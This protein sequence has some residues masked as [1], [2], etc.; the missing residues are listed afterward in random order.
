MKLKNDFWQIGLLALAFLLVA[1]FVIANS[2]CMSA[3]QIERFKGQYC[4]DSTSTVINNVPVPY[5]V[6]YEDSTYTYLWLQC[7][8]DYN[9]VVT[10]SEYYQGKYTELKTKLDSNKLVIHSHTKIH[11]TIIITQHDTIKYTQVIKPV[12]KLLKN[13]DVVLI[14]F[15]KVF[16]IEHAIF[17]LILIAYFVIKYLKKRYSINLKK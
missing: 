1:W 6:V 9:V 10:K 15:G 14:T 3:K 16:F 8:E 11:D 17:L 5:A 4:K 2:G 13:K 7:N 12:E